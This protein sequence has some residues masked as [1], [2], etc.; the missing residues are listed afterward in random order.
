MMAVIVGAL[1]V[2]AAASTL[3][4]RV[5]GA[6]AE[7][8]PVAFWLAC[9]EQVVPVATVVTFHTPETR[10]TVQID[11]SIETTVTGWPEL[12]ETINVVSVGAPT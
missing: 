7:K 12:A 10:A 9:R 4:E 6:A 2:V 11:V 3:N 1:G 5:T 8:L